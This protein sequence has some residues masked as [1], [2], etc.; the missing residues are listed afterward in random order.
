MG[1]RRRASGLID[2][3]SQFH[4][5]AHACLGV[6]AREVALDGLVA[7]ELGARRSACSTD[8]RRPVARS[9]ATASSA[10]RCG[11]P[12]ATRTSARAVS[13][14]T[15]LPG[16][17]ACTSS[18]SVA[19]PRSANPPSPQRGGRRIRRAGRPADR[20]AAG[21]GCMRATA[22][23]RG[24]RASRRA[25]ARRGRERAVHTLFRK[26]TRRLKSI[27]VPGLAGNLRPAQTPCPDG[28]LVATRERPLRCRNR[29]C[30]ADAQFS[31]SRRVGFRKG[32]DLGL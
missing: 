6:D 15:R 1:H 32:C 14:R 30:A 26:T 18:S 8:P 2:S 16:T 20:A 29:P 23:P 22:R 27:C 4:P 13:L 28:T 5:R 9:R 10:A 17:A 19:R 31:L 3:Q 12:C 7:E 21:S 11:S 24:A 25:A